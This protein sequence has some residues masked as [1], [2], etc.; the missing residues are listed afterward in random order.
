VMCGGTLE[1]VF[2]VGTSPG[3]EVA[4]VNLLVL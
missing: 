1:S 3:F 4:R 2:S